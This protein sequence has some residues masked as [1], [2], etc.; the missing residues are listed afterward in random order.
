MLIIVGKGGDPGLT[1]AT[2]HTNKAGQGLAPT[3]LHLLFPLE[4]PA[5][6]DEVIQAVENKLAKDGL[7]IKLEFTYI[8][9]DQYWNKLWL[10]AA[11]GEPYDIAL[12]AYSN[13]ADLVS[14][15]VLSTLG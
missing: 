9:Y 12:S 6:Q 14:K 3:T 8:P 1:P 5:A 7:P 11:S 4:K 13:I 2:S 15:K 10:N